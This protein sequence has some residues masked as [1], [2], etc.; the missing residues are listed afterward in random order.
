MTD[1]ERTLTVRIESAVSG[2]LI[3]GGILLTQTAL[4]F[5]GIA[6]WFLGA[7]GL[8]HALAV[9]LKFI[10]LPNDDE[11]NEESDGS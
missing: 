7:V 2:V 9:A 3:I 11:R 4:D 6:L 1:H 8:G 10:P 5:V